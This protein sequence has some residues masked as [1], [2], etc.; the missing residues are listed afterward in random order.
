M[1]PST[2]IAYPWIL[3]GYV[4]DLMLPGGMAMVVF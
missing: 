2:A 4:L 1:T 3:H